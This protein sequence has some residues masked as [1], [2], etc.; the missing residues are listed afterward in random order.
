MLTCTK[1][2]I[3]KSEDEFYNDKRARTGRT[4]WCKLCYKL[5][6]REYIPATG[7]ANLDKI[8]HNKRYLARR[9]LNN[10]VRQGKVSKRPCIVCQTK[11]SVQAHHY[12]YDRPLD[13]TWY[14]T[15]HHPKGKTNH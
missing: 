9:T 5:Y 2:S 6:A 14:C 1:C 10:A 15:K 3:P 13:V 11:I 12:D 7:R 8:V 4:S